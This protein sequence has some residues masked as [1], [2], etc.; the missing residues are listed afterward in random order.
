M[1]REDGDMTYIE[2]VEKIRTANLVLVGLGES[3]SG[4]LEHFYS[5]LAV[6]L[7]DKD[8]FIVTLKERSALEQA[9]LLPEQ[10]VSPLEEGEDSKSW[11]RYLHW[12]GFTLNQKLCIVELGVGF[13]HPSLIRFPFEKTCYFNQ[14]SILIRIHETFWQLSAEIAKRGTAIQE[15]PVLFLT[16]GEEAER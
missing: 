11:E 16:S 7:K 9:G 13:L 2:I 1:D 14:K 15:D 3:L 6:L 10:I 5:R 4:D 8:Y 12:L